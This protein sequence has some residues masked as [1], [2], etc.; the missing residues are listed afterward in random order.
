MPHFEAT[1]ALYAPA[2]QDH[3]PAGVTSH[4][5]TFKISQ[6]AGEDFQSLLQAIT[7]HI[8][9]AEQAGFTAHDLD[10]VRHALAAEVIAKAK[11]NAADPEDKEDETTVD[12]YMLHEYGSGIGMWLYHRH[13]KRENRIAVVYPERMDSLPFIPDPKAKVHKGTATLSKQDAI[14]AGYLHRSPNEFKIVRKEREAKAG[15]IAGKPYVRT[16]EVYD[17][18]VPVAWVPATELK[19]MQEEAAKA[20]AKAAAATPVPPPPPPAATNGNGRTDE[21][22][23]QEWADIPGETLDPLTRKR[24]DLRK[25]LEGFFPKMPEAHKWVI[26]VAALASG[27]ALT[28]DINTLLEPGIDYIDKA[29][30]DRP[31]NVR[32]GW[33]KEREAKANKP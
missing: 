10:Q 32:A 12:M 21:Q 24:N 3:M 30:N 15:G 6:D 28:D 5:V 31:D 18:G 1:F 11:G 8:R 19:I 17:N 14:D 20:A 22:A 27:Q 13:P 26:S 16:I 33:K 2:G 23:R 4:P 7:E 25:R 9:E 29:L